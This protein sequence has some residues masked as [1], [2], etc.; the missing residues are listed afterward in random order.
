MA[1]T[2]NYNWETPDDTDLVKDGAAAIRTL[3]SSIDTT[4]K[5]LN[6][7]TTLGDIAYRSATANVKTR[8]ALG[9]AGQ[10]LRVNSGATA[11]EWAAPAGGSTFAGCSLTKSGT[12]SIA[13]ATSVAVTFDVEEFDTDSFHS[14]ATN[15]SRI[16]I[17]SGKDGKYLFTVAGNFDANATGQRLF[18][19]Y[20]NGA[21]HKY[22]E[23]AGASASFVYQATSA[24]IA[25]AVATDYFEF[26]V[27][28]NSTASLN[29]NGGTTDTTFATS[30]LG[31]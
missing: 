4:T 12:Q 31:A 7:E 13:N 15:T 29:L 8:L 11:P 28:Q 21:A 14:N 23:R 17:P 20:K 22:L 24:V 25:E 6:P 26:Y 19:L 10:V 16:T 5:A 30:Y 27:F 1:N 9:S 2:T 18:I 3:G